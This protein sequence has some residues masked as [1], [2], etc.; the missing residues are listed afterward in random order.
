MY[1]SL[2]TLQRVCTKNYKIPDSDIVLEKG[3]Q[4]FISTIGI[5]NDPTYY[6]NPEVFNPDNFSQEMKSNRHPFAYMPFGLGPRMC[7]GKD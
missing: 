2:P 6:T 4:I 5:H 3:T 1:P 7:I